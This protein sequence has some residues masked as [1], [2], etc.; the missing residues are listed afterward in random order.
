VSLPR[1]L[2]AH[3]IYRLDVGGLENGLV[4][5]I[6]HLPRSRFRHAVICMTDYTE[7]SRRIDR[8]DVTLHS[9]HKR[10]GKDLAVYWR[11]WRL[12]RQLRPDLVHT[13]NLGSLEAQLPAWVAGVVH[14]VH[15]EHGWDITD[16]DGSNRRYQKLRKS[17]RPLVH[18]YVALSCEL[19]SY[20]ADVIEVPRAK[21]TRIYNGVDTTHFKPA[22]ASTPVAMPSDFLRPDT[23][24]FGT[25]GRMHGVKNQLLL[26]RAFCQL[27]EREP[28]ASTVARL[29]LVGDGPLRSEAE[30]IL[31]NAGLSER[32]W[33]PGPRD[34]VAAILA[35]LD[36]FVLPSLAEGISNT[37]L[38]AMAV[39]LPVIA[40]R[41]GGNPELI[42][43]DE[44]GALIA[45]DSVD[46]LQAQMFAYLS[47]AERR[48]RHGLAARER[49]KKSFSLDAMVR[50]YMAMY[51]AELGLYMPSPSVL[52]YP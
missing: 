52:P 23:T 6:N 30:V 43:E 45:S 37:I 4:N 35:A 8:D 46:E 19:E 11:L 26:V 10:P 38:E 18:R 24:V 41:V 44:T 50:R 17:F 7:F 21:L 29:V 31:R 1:P 25:V 40:T 33:M 42:A 27:V 2:I 36:V 47:D 15:S 14:R 51:E 34:D 32:V 39:G 12:F 9:L 22:D 13:R 20:L 28:E 49:V 5:L 48:L 3:V 16:P